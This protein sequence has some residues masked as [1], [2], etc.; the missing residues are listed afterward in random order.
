[1]K[2]LE[3]SLYVLGPPMVV[4]FGLAKGLR[5]P[6]SEGNLSEAGVFSEPLASPVQ[7]NVRVRKWISDPTSIR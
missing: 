7:S 4:D 3:E 5:A 6:L 1:M 2:D